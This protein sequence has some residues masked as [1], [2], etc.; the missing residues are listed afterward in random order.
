MWTALPSAD[1]YAPSDSPGGPWR[2]VGVS[3][4]YFPLAFTSLQASPVFSVE[5]SKRHAVGGVF[6]AAPSALCGSPV[7]LQGRTG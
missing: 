4:A 1:Y 6:L 2:F 3:L 7:C 5:D